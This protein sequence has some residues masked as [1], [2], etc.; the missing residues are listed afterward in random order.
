[1][2]SNFEATADFFSSIKSID[3]LVMFAENES[4]LNHEE[5][6]TLFLKLAVVSTVTKLQ[7]YIEKLLDE[8]LY[9]L[10]LVKK[11][12]KDLPLHARL[13]S[14]KLFSAQN[15]L[16]NKLE[17]PTTY[18]EQKLNDI[19]HHILDLN[20]LCDDK[21]DIGPAFLLK[22]KFPLGKNGLNELKEL[23]GQIEGNDNIF[24]TAPFDI[25]ELNAVLNIRHNIVHQD[26][27]PQL[28][29]LK[30]NEYKEFVQK[31]AVFVDS[32]L[33]QFLLGSERV[34]V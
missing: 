31:I 34:N 24:S 28:T 21:K 20:E 17:N 12:N 19:R 18:S 25:E 22:T 7:V 4:E 10:R 11:K 1:M 2:S 23:F 6:R 33:A 16:L 9:K 5:N 14:L 15:S 30:V 13:V 29:E 27:N 26:Q 32:Y 8:F 3:I